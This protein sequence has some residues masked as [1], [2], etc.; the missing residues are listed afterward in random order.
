VA[1]APKLLAS[2]KWGGARVEIEVGL[3]HA[4]EYED[5][6]FKRTLGRGKKFVMLVLSHEE[7][8]R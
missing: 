3:A 6:S 7:K 8:V 5:V 1:Q 2:G 4:N